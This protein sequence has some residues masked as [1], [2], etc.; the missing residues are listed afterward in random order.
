MNP[1]DPA[2][3]P[4]FFSTGQ[5]ASWLGLEHRSLDSEDSRQQEQAVVTTANTNTVLTILSPS[6]R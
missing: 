4:E 1:E 3:E 6:C 2:L 5:D